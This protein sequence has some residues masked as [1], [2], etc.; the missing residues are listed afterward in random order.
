MRARLRGGPAE[1][2]GIVGHSLDQLYE[3]MAF[4]AFHFH[5][6]LDDIMALD[7]A[8]RRRWLTTISQLNQRLNQ[9]AV[10]A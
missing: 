3:E 8:E 1:P 7:H 6:S 5:W 10:H 9:E 4:I 2:G